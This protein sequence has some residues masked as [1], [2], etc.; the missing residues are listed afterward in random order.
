M[1]EQ[2]RSNANVTRLSAGCPLSGIKRRKASTVVPEDA[3][4]E[5]VAADGGRER[6][7]ITPHGRPRGAEGGAR[8]SC[9]TGERDRHFA[10]ELNNK[11]NVVVGEGCGTGT[12]QSGDKIARYSA[13]MSI[14]F[15]EEPPRPMLQMTVRWCLPIPPVTFN[16]CIS[17]HVCC[18]I[19]DPCNR[20]SLVNAR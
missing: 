1:C 20:A 8:R 7:G 16:P 10:F 12:R 13:Y 17:H 18:H 11:I 19:S 14:D 6:A 3:H 5:V 4:Q 15:C 2:G 9:G